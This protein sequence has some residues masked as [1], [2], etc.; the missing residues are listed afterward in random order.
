M[1]CWIFN[2]APYSS[3]LESLTARQIYERRMQDKFWGLGE[4]TQNRRSVR[5]GDQV[6]FYIARPDSV[7]VGTAR[8][9]S[10]SFDL[11]PKERANLSHGSA[12]FTVEHGVW[13][14]AIDTW[15]QSRSIAVMVSSL[16]F[17]KNPAQWWTHLQGGVR[18]IEESD[19][20][21][22]VSSVNAPEPMGRAAE[23]SESRKYWVVS[24][25]VQFDYH[26]V[27]EWR[28][29]SVK[30]K[31]A[32]MGW[33]TEDINHRLGRKFAYEIDPGDTV[34]IAR[35]HRKETEIVGF[36]NVVGKFK[37]HIRG[38]KPPQPFGSLRL[39]DPFVPMTRPPKRL[40]FIEAL[41]QIAALHRLHPDRNPNHEV[42]CRWMDSK[43]ANEGNPN[44]NKLSQ[45][46]AAGI[47]LRSFPNDEQ[48]EYQVRTPPLVKQARKREAELIK[49]YRVWIERQDRE[50]NIFSTEKIQCDA[51]E[52]ARNNLIE[53]KCSVEREY[54]RMAVGQVLDYA[55]QAKA[56]LGICNK[57]ILLPSRPEDNVL[58]WIKSLGI[59]AIWEDRSAFLDNAN[60]Q[61]T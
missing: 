54:V 45:G 30:W 49:R 8:L 35:R 34:L 13:L 1:N 51:Y 43:L 25:N 57:A 6:V 27:G 61:F 48:L 42:L 22:I 31:A 40:P 3:D 39:L 59:S 9:A 50:L 24:P 16:K 38:F 10:D 15:E 20:Q 17:I 12:F 18:Q 47:Q 58:K 21:T 55:F 7:F 29:A 26:T 32:F 23:V 60:G 37:T 11:T 5:K 52:K 19:Y 14:D 44:R 56:E 28:Q 36:G 33:G 53:A 4:R 46:V 2:A 41:N